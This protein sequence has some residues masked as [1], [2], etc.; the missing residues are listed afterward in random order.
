MITFDRILETLY[1]LDPMDLS[2]KSAYEHVAERIYGIFTDEESMSLFEAIDI[3]FDMCFDETVNS[4]AIASK[5]K[6]SL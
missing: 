5:M 4:M 3:A 1:E 6:E 2:C